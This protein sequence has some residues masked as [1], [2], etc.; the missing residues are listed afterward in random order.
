MR[1]TGTMEVTLVGCDPL[2]AGEEMR[3]NYEEGHVCWDDRDV[4]RGK[5][6]GAVRASMGHVS[7]FHDVYTLL[8]CGAL[9]VW[10][11]EVVPRRAV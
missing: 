11:A 4:L 7:T 5:P 2:S 10:A 3:E 6:T 9:W 8:R 1:A